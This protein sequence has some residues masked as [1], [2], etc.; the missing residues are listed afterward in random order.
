[1]DNSF[2]LC[3]LPPK[4]T[5]NEALEFIKLRTEP[6]AASEIAKA[7]IDAG[8]EHREIWI[9]L[10]E[11]R[12]QAEV[13]AKTLREL[14]DVFAVDYWSRHYPSSLRWI[15]RFPWV[16]FHKGKL[17]N[18]SVA[19]LAVVGTRRP[20][21]YGREVVRSI[22]PYIKTRPLHVVSGLAYGV[23]ALA[24]QYSCDC[25]IPNFAV[26]GCGIDQ[27]YPPEH[28][29]LA[30]RIIELKGGIL[31]EFPPGTPALPPH[32]PRRNRIISGLADVVWVVQGTGKSGSLHTVK[33][34]LQ[35]SRT[36]VTTPGDI[37]S[38]LSEVPHR[39]LIDGAFPIVRAADLDQL[40]TSAQATITH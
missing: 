28:L 4:Y 33:H 35:Q 3:H 5:H 1:M 6:P 38:E 24:H 2:I 40:L 39:L 7:L 14:K 29:P 8:A 22:L 16:L 17:P 13:T 23:D 20:D 36:V 15:D 27:I 9:A 10:D 25:K 21:R 34:A 31:S 18:D 11:A 19:T 26:L 30:E 37:F 32:F 12:R